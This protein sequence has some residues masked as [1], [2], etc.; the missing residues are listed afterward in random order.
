MPD[1][2]QWAD[3]TGSLVSLRAV[4]RRNGL[5]QV[6]NGIDLDL[7]GGRVTALLGPPGAGKT[8]LCRALD[9]SER[10]DSGSI[11]VAGV[12]LRRRH[13]RFA[14]TYGDGRAGVAPVAEPGSLP[15]HRTVL[16]NVAAGPRTG[17]AA[18]WRPGRTDAERRAP[19]LLERVG[20][21]DYAGYFP[22][23]LSE[24]LQQ[25][26]AIARALAGSPVLLLVDLPAS[27]PAVDGRPP[28]RSPNV[29]VPAAARPT[30]DPATAPFPGTSAVGVL[31]ALPELLRGIAADGLAVLVATDRPALARATADR[32]VF[33]EGGRVI[34]QGPTEDFFTTPRTARARAF[35]SAAAAI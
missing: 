20:A 31:P 24:E 7:P 28:D 33:L 17:S 15:A 19:A 5:V 22:W 12:P 11:T 35:L 6:L 18:R 14:R 30:A 8:M 2:V 26:V 16:Q 21:A 25:R 13:R 3:G 32:V 23:E 1:G 27:D 29:P 4:N 34:E 9:G 10:I